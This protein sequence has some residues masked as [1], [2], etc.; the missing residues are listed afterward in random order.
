MQEYMTGRVLFFWFV[1]RPRA[2]RADCEASSAS[3][4]N[5]STDKDRAVAVFN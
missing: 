2:A 5:G 1:R 4:G 3:A